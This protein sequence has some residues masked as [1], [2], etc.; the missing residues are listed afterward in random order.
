MNES[1]TADEKH[2]ADGKSSTIGKVIRQT[3]GNVR[4]H[5]FIVQLE[6]MTNDE[7]IKLIKS[8]IIL[9]K[10]F[11]T[12]ITDLTQANANLCQREEVSRLFGRANGTVRSFVHQS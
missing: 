6:S 12:K 1:T 11:E 10:K 3:D 9:K 7:L 8:Q 4:C 2:H 5:V